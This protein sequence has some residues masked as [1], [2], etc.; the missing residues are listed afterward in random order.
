[1]RM[2]TL[3]GSAV[4]FGLAWLSGCTTEGAA[5]REALEEEGYTDV[6]VESG[7]AGGFTWTGQKGENACKGTLKIS[8]TL[9]SGNCPAAMRVVAVVQL[10]TPGWWTPPPSMH[11]SPTSAAS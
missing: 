5:A 4:V 10:P 2:R 11:P 9:L 3:I 8:T 6:E 7:T 1:M